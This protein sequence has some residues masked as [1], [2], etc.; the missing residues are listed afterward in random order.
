MFIAIDLIRGQHILEFTSK[1]FETVEILRRDLL[2]VLR[3]T[4]T[5]AY[6]ILVKPKLEY[7][8][9]L[10]SSSLNSD[11]AGCQGLYRTTP[12]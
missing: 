8:I 5:A 11:L 3:Y 10:T 4:K 6:E 9:C 2:F 7:T 1:T 12:R